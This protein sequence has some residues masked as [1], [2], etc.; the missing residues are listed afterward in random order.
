VSQPPPDSNRPTP[1]QVGGDA[2]GIGAGSG[3]IAFAI[4]QTLPEPYRFWL[5]AAAHTISATSAAIW[6][7]LRLRMARR[8]SEWEMKWAIR[9]AKRTLNKGI[10]SKTV[11]ASHR[12]GLRKQLEELELLEVRSDLDVAKALNKKREEQHK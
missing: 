4:A 12:A 2:I 9:K 3:T 6:V 10:S 5:S 7:F 11:S 1:T 8:W